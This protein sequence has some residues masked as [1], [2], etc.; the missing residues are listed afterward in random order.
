MRLIY[1]ICIISL[2]ISN[3]HENIITLNELLNDTQSLK[4]NISY[5]LGD[6]IL[7]HGQNN[8]AVT[9]YLKYNSKNFEGKLEYDQFGSH[10]ILNLETDMDINF[11][12]EFNDNT[13]NL[14]YNE[15][16]LYISPVIPISLNLGVGMGNSLISL[17]KIKVEEFNL[18]C[19]LCETQID[20][21]EHRN[22]I[23][24]SSLDVD[25]GLGTV[26]IKNLI[27]LNTTDMDFDCGLG[28]ME[29]D[30][31]GVLL[32]EIYVDLSVG[33][34]SVDLIFQTGTNVIFKY[35]GSFLSNVDLS[36]FRYSGDEYYSIPFIEDN[37]SIVITGSI[38]AGTLDIHWIEN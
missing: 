21:G 33:L 2:G 3:S 35:D 34:G 13:K 9:G 8:M 29:L 7:E 15:A 17:D 20:I 16:E 24:C 38:G 27:N 12:W 19:G 4:V 36:D 22:P 6:L 32:N 11:D 5:S 10:G 14:I 18:D 25:A 26:K 28:T 30:F 31:T 1:F 23:D 37:P